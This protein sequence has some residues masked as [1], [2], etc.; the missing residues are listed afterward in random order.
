M[1]SALL[2]LWIDCAPQRNALCIYL[3]G[4]WRLS[5]D[6][7]PECPSPVFADAAWKR[8][9]LPHGDLCFHVIAG[10]LRR[11]AAPPQSPDK[12]RG[13]YDSMMVVRLRRVV[14]RKEAA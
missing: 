14:I 12:A 8:S 6:H 1:K 4:E 7:L 2:L 11:P 9:A 10:R 3:T 5:A 13:R